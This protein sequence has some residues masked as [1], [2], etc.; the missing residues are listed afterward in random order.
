M[1]EIAEINKTLEYFLSD[2]V[3]VSITIDDIRL[4]SNLKINQTLIFT[5]K[6]IFYI[7]LGFIE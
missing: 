4:E 6:S 3:K 2:N 7:K 5:N 1:Y